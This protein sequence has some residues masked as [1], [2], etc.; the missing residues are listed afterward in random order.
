MKTKLKGAKEGI[1]TTDNSLREL[2][3]KKKGGKCFKF[4]RNEG[5][6]FK[7]AEE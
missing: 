3:G 4:K 2:E 5:R 1:N 7:T 6:T